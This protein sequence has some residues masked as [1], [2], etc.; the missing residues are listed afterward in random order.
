MPW[1]TCELVC[2]LRI[3]GTLFPLTE[4]GALRH[5]LARRQNHEF[6]VR[7]IWFEH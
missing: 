4:G 3:A 7:L 6:V 2:L 5:G 1:V